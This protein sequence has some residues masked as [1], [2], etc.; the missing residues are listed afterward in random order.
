MLSSSQ[1]SFKNSKLKIL[2]SIRY[3]VA[4]MEKEQ[5]YKKKFAWQKNQFFILDKFLRNTNQQK[6]S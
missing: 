3:L 4:F 6:I 5:Y 1:K 2:I